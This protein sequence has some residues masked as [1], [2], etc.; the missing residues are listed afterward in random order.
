MSPLF[1]GLAVI[2]AFID[3]AQVASSAKL[4]LLPNFGCIGSLQAFS[5]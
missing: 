5:N 1:R 2:A 4:R 3:A